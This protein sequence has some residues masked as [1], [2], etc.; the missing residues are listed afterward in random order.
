MCGEGRSKKEG[1]E[2]PLFTKLKM[3]GPKVVLLLGVGTECSL[4]C[5]VNE[6]E[7]TASVK[8][9]Y[10]NNFL[11]KR[12]SVTRFFTSLFS[13]SKD[14]TCAPHEQF[15]NFFVFVTIFDCKFCTYLSEN[16]KVPKLCFLF[17][18]GTCI[19]WLKRGSK[20]RDTVP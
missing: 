18:R 3:N 4:Y 13:S 1:S 11:H 6:T 20:F 12:D 5:N 14:S 2:E 16:E 19:F 17:I 8:V 10:N 7:N 9:K 15:G